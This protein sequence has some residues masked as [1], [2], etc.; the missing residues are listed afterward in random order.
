MA[1]ETVRSAG[2]SGA[3][4]DR[5]ALVKQALER[6]GPNS[7]P[8]TVLMRESISKA[9]L[10]NAMEWMEPREPSRAMRRGGAS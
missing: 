6:G 9:T 2:L 3:T 1:G 10:E 4:V 8:A 5:K 7:S